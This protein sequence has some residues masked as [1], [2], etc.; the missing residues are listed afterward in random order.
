MKM[1]F[2]QISQALN[3]NTT[4]VLNNKGKEL[5]QSFYKLISDIEKS[6]IP[7]IKPF[8][9]DVEQIKKDIAVQ[10]IST[11]NSRKLGVEEFEIASRLDTLTSG[12]KRLIDGN[13]FV[14]NKDDKILRYITQ[15]SYL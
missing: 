12:G 3:E 9:T 14:F 8:V 2:E 4:F 5:L 15:T 10:I 13:K 6:V 1:N 7:I 11:I